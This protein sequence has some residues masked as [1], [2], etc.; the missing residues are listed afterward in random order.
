[1]N[2]TKLIILLNTIYVWNDLQ[3]LLNSFKSSFTSLV[4]LGKVATKTHMT[5]KGFTIKIYISR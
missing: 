3:E 5:Q 4:L 1:M 2:T